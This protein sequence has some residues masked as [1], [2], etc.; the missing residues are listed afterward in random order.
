MNKTIKTDVIFE[1]EIKKSRFICQL[2]R[3]YT[4]DEARA[5]IAAVKKQH[6]KANHNVSAFTIG[7]N[8]E[9]QRSSDDGEP[10]GT[11]GIPMLEI[12]KKR[13]LINVAAVVTRYF[14][15]IKLGAGGLIRAYA[16]SVN[17]AIDTVGLVAIVEQTQVDLRLDYGLFDQ[18][19]RYLT[20]AGIAIAN[21]EFTSDVLVTV[22]VAS[23]TVAQLKSE[24]TELCHGKL[25]MAEGDKKLVE[26]EI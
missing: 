19:S 17:H 23:D 20:R 5:F 12:L 7:D 13:E 22:F 26:I 1:E 3:V 25:T 16:G 24:L 2:K 4:E 6:H 15:G 9:I 8:Q 18:V 21:S 11:A 10:S 14:G